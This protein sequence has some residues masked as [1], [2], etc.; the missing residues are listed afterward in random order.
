MPI[1]KIYEIT[2]DQSEGRYIGSTM[3]K[4]L[5]SRFAEHK[6]NYKE[7]QNGGKYLSSFDILKHD[8]ATIT[9]L[10]EFEYDTKANLKER[11]RE[12]IE[13]NDDTVNRYKPIRTKEDVHAAQ[14]IATKTYRENHKEK[15]AKANLEWCRKNKE[16]LYA[17]RAVLVMCECGRQYTNGHKSRHEKS[18][19]HLK[20]L[21]L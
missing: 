16:K 20:N 7:Y 8:D 18:S 1:G 14:R 11:E 4:Y 6:A 10:E 9:L 5:S 3:K 12:W 17:K 15:V 19:T 13:A 21:K 2:S